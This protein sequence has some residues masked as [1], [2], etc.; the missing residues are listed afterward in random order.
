MDILFF[1]VLLYFFLLYLF[2]YLFI[3]LE[4]SESTEIFTEMRGGWGIGPRD[5]EKIG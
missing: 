3:Y 2:I 5:M 4:R 1:V